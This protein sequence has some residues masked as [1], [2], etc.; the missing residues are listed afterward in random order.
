MGSAACCRVVSYDGSGAHLHC[1]RRPLW[2]LWSVLPAVLVMV[3]LFLRVWRRRVAPARRAGRRGNEGAGRTHR[4]SRVSSGEDD[5]TDTLSHEASSDAAVK[6]DTDLASALLA[7]CSEEARARRH[8]TFASV[9][10]AL[11]FQKASVNNQEEHYE[12][13]LLSHLALYRGDY[14]QACSRHVHVHDHAHAHAH[15][16]VHVHTHVHVAATATM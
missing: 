10:V 7:Q 13:L 3:L 4:P 8:E 11:G 5:P 1:I 2:L 12:S 16:H 6:E 15:V 9:S 14:A